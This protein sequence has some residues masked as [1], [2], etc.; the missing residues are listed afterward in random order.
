MS[1]YKR[2][3]SVNFWCIFRF[4][5]KRIRQSTGT[6]DEAKAEEYEAKLRATLYDQTR[7]GVK[8]AHT[9]KSAVGRYVEETAHKSLSTRQGD[10]RIFQWLD[11]YLANATLEA[12][13]RALID[14]LIAKK[15]AEGVKPRTV[16]AVTNLIRAVMRKA[17]LDWEWIDRLPK[18][19]ILPEPK[20]RIRYISREEAARL[21]AELP[22]HLRKMA[23]LALETGLRRYNI[24]HL[25]WAQVDLARRMAWVHPDEAKAGKAIPVP[26]SNA[27]V[28]ILR[29]CRGDDPEFVFVYKGNPVHN[30]G[31]R[32]WDKACARAGIEDFRWHDL[33]H[34]WASWHIQDGT[35]LHILQELGGWEDVSM[36]RKYA[37][38]SVSHLS[39]YVQK[40][41]TLKSVE[42]ENAD[43]FFATGRKNADSRNL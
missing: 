14:N 11:K 10:V 33:R 12:I 5:G 7:L 13:D 35:P 41:D 26:L 1:L 32:A 34:T 4:N 38:L 25:R 42:S 37:H 27:A 2:A 20:R 19:R 6:A 23:T 39:E 15:Q 17:M 31:T 36:V 8:G 43:T 28:I 18:F 9:W 3:D 16:N 40:R 30:T 21:L 29:E 22:D 24:T